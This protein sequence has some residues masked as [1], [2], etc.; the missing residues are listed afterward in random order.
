MPT[1]ER[2]FK[3]CLVAA[4]VVYPLAAE[5]KFL[6]F[7]FGVSLVSLGEDVLPLSMVI[8][9]AVKVLLSGLRGGV[10]YLLPGLLVARAL[11]AARPGLWL[12]WRVVCWVGLPL[13]GHALAA[14][15]FSYLNVVVSLGDSMS[16]EE[17][18]R[19][20]WHYSWLF[21]D[22]VSLSV[23]LLYAL[24]TAGLT[25][26][27]RRLCKSPLRAL[28]ALVSQ[29]P[30]Y[31]AGRVVPVAQAPAP[32]PR[33]A[34]APL[35]MA[36][37]CAAALSGVVWWAGCVL[38]LCGAGLE[39]SWCAAFCVGLRALMLDLCPWLLLGQVVAQLLPRRSG[40]LRGVGSCLFIVFG[41]LFSAF[42]LTE[43]INP[44]TLAP[45]LLLAGVSLL[46]VVPALIVGLVCHVRL[47]RRLYPPSL[48]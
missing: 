3:A 12:P 17:C 5:L 19:Y 44:T 31:I 41:V 8:S 23:A 26:G 18:W 37:L 38:V 22:C 7:P 4:C 28:R 14:T 6:V 32:A 30:A 35:Y 25:E 34:A 45:N 46:C 11:V 13:L 36:P 2:T 10:V 1:F 9:G 47:L 48:S 27:E 40:R 33:L 15:L 16:L 39:I 24:Y 29:L 42:E 21:A 20:F 43:P